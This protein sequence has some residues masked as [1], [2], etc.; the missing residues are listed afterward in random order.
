MVQ[1]GVQ[2]DATLAAPLVVKSPPPPPPP[3]R[4]VNRGIPCVL[5]K[6]PVKGYFSRNKV[7]LV[8]VHTQTTLYTPDLGG[9]FKRREHAY[10]YPK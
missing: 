1:V 3:P 7:R 2:T 10:A 8:H 9:V 6:C 4:S 5:P